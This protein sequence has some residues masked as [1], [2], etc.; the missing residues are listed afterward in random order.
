MRVAPA[1]AIDMKIELRR[2]RKRA[3]EVFR[4]LDGEVSNHLPSRRHVVNKIEPARQID[5]RPAQCL[6]HRHH[7]FTVAIYPTFIAECLDEGLAERERDVFD[8]MMIVDLEIALTCN[9]Q[10]E[11]PVFG[12]QFEHVFEKRKADRDTRVA[13]AVEIEIDTHVCLFRLAVNV[14]DS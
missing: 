14:C 9:L 12:E 1:Q 10:V 4:E 7:G 2:L 5:N 6:V 11:Q 3:P 13:A 8:G